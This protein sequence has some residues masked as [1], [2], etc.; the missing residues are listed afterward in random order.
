MARYRAVLV[1]VVVVVMGVGMLWALQRK[2]IYF[3]ATDTPV[4]PPGVREVALTTADDV[5]LT[6]WLLAPSTPDIAVLVAPGNAGNR[7]DRLA[8]A[9][10]LVGKGFT[11]L[12]LD[13][14]GYGGNPGS[15]SEDGLAHD[16]R[17]AWDHLTGPGGFTAD[18]VVLF[19]E[20]L[21]AAVVTRLATEVRPRGVVL[22]S[23]FASL[24]A[25]GKAHYP[26]LPVGLL[27]RDRFPVV[28]RVRNVTA[29]TVVVYGTRDTVVP[30][31][32]SR[33]VAGAAA[34]LVDTVAVDGAG[35]NDAVL[36]AG[37]V[38]TGAVRKVVQ[39]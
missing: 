18:R 29:P 33:A 28:E 8:L 35:H 17:A 32:Q 34:N 30:P 24:V 9:D 25:A 36:N 39:T 37:S 26:L 13:Y 31:E 4:P 19:G 10:D 23:P 6:A 1:V 16:V 15:P 27:L 22:R 3:P 11:V 38:V 20:S 5:R 2:L 21:G 12:L 14:R 7:G